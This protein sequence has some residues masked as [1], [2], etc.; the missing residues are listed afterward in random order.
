MM[1]RSHAVPPR[2]AENISTRGGKYP[3]SWRKITLL[4]QLLRLAGQ[5]QW[6]ILAAVSV[7]RTKERTTKRAFL[8]VLSLQTVDAIRAWKGEQKDNSLKPLPRAV[9]LNR[10]S[11][12][13]CPQVGLEVHYGHIHKRP[14]VDASSSGVSQLHRHTLLEATPDA[15]GHS[16]GLYAIADTHQVS[17]LHH[18]REPLLLHVLSFFSLAHADRDALRRWKVV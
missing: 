13:W 6:N 4:L 3:H 12:M 15:A 11:A 18:S 5:Y 2:V 1:K 17:E 8:S 10:H 7:A 9:C 14:F 16:P